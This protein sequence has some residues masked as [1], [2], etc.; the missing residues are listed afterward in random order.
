MGRTRS[1]KTPRIF[2]IKAF[3]VA[4]FIMAIVPVTQINSFYPAR[5]ILSAVIMSTVGA[6]VGLIIAGKFFGIVMS[7]VGII[8]L[9]GIVVRY[10]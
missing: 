7:G 5:F 4:L 8:A 1:K 6:M 10:L 2:F 9:A 3:G